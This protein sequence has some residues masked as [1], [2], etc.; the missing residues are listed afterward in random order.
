MSK[1]ELANL[2]PYVDPY[3]FAFVLLLVK[4]APFFLF[5]LFYLH[6]LYIN[7]EREISS[8]FVN[9]RLAA[10]P[11]DNKTISGRSLKVEAFQDFN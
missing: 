8:S 1:T 9:I 10:K 5:L 3:L 2:S 7:T 11:Q 6:L 4:W